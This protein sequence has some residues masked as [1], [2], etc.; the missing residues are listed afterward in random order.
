MKRCFSN[1]VI[2]TV[3]LPDSACALALVMYLSG[4]LL[5]SDREGFEHLNIPFVLFSFDRR[6][7]HWISLTGSIGDKSTPLRQ[8]AHV[9]QLNAERTAM[10]YHYIAANMNPISTEMISES[11]SV[12]IGFMFAAI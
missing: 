2:V 7:N 10:K 5:V 6:G 4:T 12:L 8:T 11:S 9:V 1:S 3:S